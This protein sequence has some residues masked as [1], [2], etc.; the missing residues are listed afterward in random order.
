MGFKHDIEED[1]RGE[2]LAKTGMRALPALYVVALIDILLLIKTLIKLGLMVILATATKSAGL[3]KT[4]TAHT[5][6]ALQYTTQRMQIYLD[7][8]QISPHVE[9]F[10]RIFFWLVFFKSRLCRQIL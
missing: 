8:N 10:Q 6:K 3:S 2:I 4:A 5:P 7:G 1:G 9:K